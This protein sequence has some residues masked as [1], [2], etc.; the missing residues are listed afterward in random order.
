M[1]TPHEGKANK[2]TAMVR[3]K[4]K[5]LEEEDVVRSRVTR[6]LKALRL[7]T[8]YTQE[9][10]AELLGVTRQFYHYMERGS[11]TLRLHYLI[12][13]SEFYGVSLDFICK[14]KPKQVEAKIKEVGA[15]DQLPIQKL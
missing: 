2:I 9:E 10:L 11:K 1:S 4:R 12:A 6:V 8:G 3:G 5:I 15:N 14:A 7:R 13:I